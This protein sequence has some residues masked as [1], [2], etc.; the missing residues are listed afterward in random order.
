MSNFQ[1]Q[2]LKNLT[3]AILKN[4]LQYICADVRIILEILHFF[5]HPIDRRWNQVWSGFQIRT[6]K[7]QT[8][9]K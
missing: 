4:N 9:T 2:T 8:E 3:E 5:E 1:T 6:S 7:W